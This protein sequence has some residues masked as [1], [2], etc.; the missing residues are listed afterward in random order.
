MSEYKKEAK[1]ASAA[2][3]QRMGLKLADGSKSFTDERGGSP[4]EGLNSG[5]AGKMPITP[6]KFKR[7]GK[8]G[9][10]VHVE[11][12]MARKN[13]GKS[14]RSKK[15]AGGASNSFK[16]LKG[17]PNYPVPVPPRRDEE[18][19]NPYPYKLTP[20]QIGAQYEERHPNEP[21]DLKSNTTG[22]ARGGVIGRK[23]AAAM[24]YK[25]KGMGMSSK[26]GIPK[27]K[28]MP[29]LAADTY[30]PHKKGGAAKHTDE[31]QDKK[32][33]HKVL[34][35]DAFKERAHKNDGGEIAGGKKS[36]HYWDEGTKLI[37]SKDQHSF[38]DYNQKRGKNAFLFSH[39]LAKE[40]G[41]TPPKPAG[42]YTFEPDE[43]KNG[44]R[45][46][47]VSGGRL[48]KYIKAASIDAATQGS[49]RGM[50][51]ATQTYSTLPRDPLY[52]EAGKK[53]RNRL[54]G[55]RTA[56]NKLGGGYSNVPAGE[57]EG[58]KKGGRAHKASGGLLSNYADKAKQ[59]L[60][61]HQNS[62]KQMKLSNLKS[63]MYGFDAPY[64]PRDIMETEKTISKR[65][66]GL[67][68]ARN[69]MSGNANVPATDDE[70]MKK[71]G[72]AEKCWGGETKRSKKFGGGALTGANP[73]I[74]PQMMANN[75]RQNMQPMRQ[76]MGQ[77]MGGYGATPQGYAQQH[78]I[79]APPPYF[80]GGN[81]FANSILGGG[82]GSM[83]QPG[84]NPPAPYFGG[85]LGTL[86]GGNPGGNLSVPYFGGNMNQQMPPQAVQDAYN[87]FN[88]Q[89]TA[90][91]MNGA[92]TAQM[93]PMGNISGAM[94][95]M[96]GAAGFG[97]PQRATGGRAKGKTNV[98]II[99]SP[100]SGQQG[101]MG[102]GVGMGMPPMPP[103][104]PPM[105][106]QGMPPMPPGGGAP[107]GA[108]QLPPQLM[109]AMAAQG[110]AGGPPMPRKT[111]GRVENVMP[112]YQEKEFG[113]GSGRG[114]LEKIKWPFADGTE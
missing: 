25:S 20:A 42:H 97:R 28:G 1:S 30:I 95:A 108:P 63:E 2:K 40:E 34:K 84:G 41:R 66:R 44:G 61:A 86:N 85:G 50:D 27:M 53:E 107:G 89:Q 23:Q 10:N 4:F 113:S 56:V 22:N 110:G 67:D 38:D 74:N 77:H 19:Y 8:V 35:E 76:P 70:G 49:R 91:P 14:A 54:Q 59:N 100:Q 83:M 79:G 48:G 29:N 114:R 5:N 51:L 101:P 88:Q 81:P 96:A 78:G 98:N 37:K 26:M 104:M 87:Q 92:Q 52:P 71:G 55:I 65:Q 64:H 13:L 94:G 7:G 17:I 16:P 21:N 105:P 3:M 68:M 6:S 33:M 90:A 106:P 31:A 112:K 75:M 58:M 99:I 62:K 32:L 45:A 9:K 82:L 60:S 69:K 73:M 57:D 36:K 102:A 39:H 47:K 46:H 72:R 12:E 24:A 109:A 15:A 43:L 111:G 18:D 93:N 103:Q 11:G 80:G